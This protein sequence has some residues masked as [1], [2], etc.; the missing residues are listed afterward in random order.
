MYPMRQFFMFAVLLSAAAKDAEKHGSRYAH[1]SLRLKLVHKNS[2]NS[3]LRK[4]FSSPQEHLANI[5]HDDSIRV[6]GLQRVLEHNGIAKGQV[7]NPSSSMYD[8]SA[9]FHKKNFKAPIISGASAGSGQYF[10]DFYIGTPPQK[11]MLIA[12]TGS[13]L[14]WVRCS[15]CK[16]CLRKPGS[17]FLSRHSSTFMPIHCYAPT[18]KLVPHPSAASCNRTVLHSSCKYDYIYA[19]QS[20]SSGIF[21]RETATLNTSTGLSAKI[22]NVAFGCGVKSSGP[23]VTGPAFSGAHGVMGLG[24]GAIS[25]TSQLG[26][27][28]GKRFSYCLVD[29]TISPPQSSYLILGQ[30]PMRPSLRKSMRYTPFLKNR[31]AETFYYVGIK[32]VWVEG[33]LLPIHPSVWNIDLQ[34][35]G[36]TVIDS[37]TTLTFIV[38]PAYRIILAA[39]NKAVIYP[40]VRPVQ[41]L[42]LCFNVSGI[43]TPKLPKMT[44]VFEGNGRFEPPPPNYFI[45]AADDIK[46]LALQGVSSPSAF[47]ILGNLMQQNFYFVYDREYSRLGFAPTDC[48]LS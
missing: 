35:N 48:S 21:S 5:V 16:K 44:I 13:D 39:F 18:C 3:P 42:G 26:K 45:N 11:L 34:G 12:D 15:G 33:V 2:L 40:R 22:K 47:S 46:C 14:L 17:A 28:V 41:D 25:L 1:P 43:S 7:F 4:T 24:K 23:S 38:E 29:Y 37:G 9:Y 36:G 32:Q 10:V 27:R 31:F 6:H 8:Q 30:A 20:D 19:D